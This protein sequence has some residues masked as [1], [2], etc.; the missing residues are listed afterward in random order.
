MLRVPLLRTARGQ[1]SLELRATSLWNKLQ[2]ELKLSE[3]V[4]SFKRQP[5]RLLLDA[6]F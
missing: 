6:S 3:F 2:P 5:R 4:K 1:R